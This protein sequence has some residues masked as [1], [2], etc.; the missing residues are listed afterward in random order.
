MIQQKHTFYVPYSDTDKMGCA[1]HSNYLK[2]YE[3]AR[4]E[5]LRNIGLPYSEIE[6][7][8]YYL[9][10]ISA[11]LHF[12]KPSTYD[13]QLTVH[14]RLVNFS[15]AKVNFNYKIYNQEHILINEGDTTLAFV[16]KENWKPCA[17]PLFFKSKINDYL[18]NND[19]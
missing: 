11:N 3:V 6:T 5:L 17:I 7:L 12:Q 4:W 19:I 8:G 18:K 13:S 16:R 10:V 2:Y 9:P 1:H 14:S 15:G